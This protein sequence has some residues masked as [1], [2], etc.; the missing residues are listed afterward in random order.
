MRGRKKRGKKLP[1]NS[2]RILLIVENS[3]KEFFQQYFNHFITENYNIKIVTKSSGSGDK[4]EITNF[5]KMS[6]KIEAFLTKDDYKA[7]FVMIDLDSQC[8][9]IEQNHNCLVK[10]KEEY[11][12]KYSI[13]KDLRDRFYLFVVCNEIES[14]FLTIDKNK[15]HTNNSNENHKK[16]MMKLF[17]VRNEKEI[18][19]KMLAELRKGTISLDFSKNNSLLHFIKKLKEFNIKKD[20]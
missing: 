9:G 17:N 15:K 6:R 13:K 20:L 4:C 7:V 18:V 1:K 11:Q 12:P 3:E 5:K 14:W 2:D 19:E 10:L 16:E 8:F